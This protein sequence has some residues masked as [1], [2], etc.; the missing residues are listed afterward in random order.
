MILLLRSLAAALLVLALVLPARAET[1]PGADD[2]AL[3]AAVARWL[4]GDNVPALMDIAGMA[5]AGN[6]AAVLSEE[7]WRAHANMLLEAGEREAVF[8]A[9]Q[10]TG[11]PDTDYIPRFLADIVR[12]DDL[13]WAR[14]W[15]AKWFAALD[16]ETAPPFKRERRAAYLRE[17]RDGDPWTEADE[18]AFR[19]AVA[20]ERMIALGVLNARRRLNQGNLTQGPGADNLARNS[21][22]LQWTSFKANQPATL[23]TQQDMADTGAWLLAEADRLPALISLASL[24]RARC[25]ESP[26]TCA[27]A[28]ALIGMNLGENDSP[29]E[30]PILQDVWLRSEKAQK[31]VL[32]QSRSL[33][34]MAEL[35]IDLEPLDQCYLRE[36]RAV[37]ETRQLPDRADAVAW[38]HERFQLAPTAAFC[39][40]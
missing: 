40:G 29:L 9:K 10:I 28:A 30:A 23:P 17:L 32:Y 18:R 33:R 3:R 6:V 38:R 1:I 26:A 2:P 37:K 39:R 24:C 14:V 22:A 11:P 36:L 34:M 13:P 31:V 8:S 7:T 19:A 27:H 5:R 16:I 35:G 21:A 4:D 12:M 15:G 25:P 20:E